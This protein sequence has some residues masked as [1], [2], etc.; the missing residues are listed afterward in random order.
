MNHLISFL[1]TLKDVSD[2]LFSYQ[3]GSGSWKMPPS[4]PSF[5]SIPNSHLISRPKSFKRLPMGSENVLLPPTLQKPHWQ[6]SIIWGHHQGLSL[7]A[8]QKYVFTQ[9]VFTSIWQQK[10]V[11]GIQMERENFDK[12]VIL[13]WFDYL[14]AMFLLLLAMSWQVKKLKWGDNFFSNSSRHVLWQVWVSSV[15]NAV[16][17]SCVV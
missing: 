15:Q 1:G 13:W 5:Q 9:L 3:R 7:K 16:F 2:I 10:F 11:K 6:V 12:N 4:L 8:A 17:D 14:E